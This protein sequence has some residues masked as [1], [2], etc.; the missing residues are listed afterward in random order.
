MATADQMGAAISPGSIEYGQRGEVESMLGN[1]MRAR[2]Q[3]SGA[4]V[5]GGLPGPSAAGGSPDEL[6]DMLV[7]GRVKPL[8][9]LPL[10]DGLSV[11]PGAGRM[12]ETASTPSS[13]EDR[14]RLIA[15]NAKTPQLRAMARMALRSETRRRMHSGG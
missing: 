9:N 10:T 2:Q 12:Q 7:G 15:V 6:L 11:G 1:V 13:M 8:P 3:Q 4:P 14:L 5:A